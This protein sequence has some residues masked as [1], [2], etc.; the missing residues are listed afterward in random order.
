MGTITIHTCTECEY[1]QDPQDDYAER[2]IVE[3]IICEEWVCD[4]CQQEH[5]EWECYNK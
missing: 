1:Y 5:A 2:G 4:E 3:C